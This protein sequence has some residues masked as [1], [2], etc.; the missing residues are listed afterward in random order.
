MNDTWKEFLD[1]ITDP[2]DVKITGL[3]V[4]KTLNP[5]FWEDKNHLNEEITNRLY[6]IAKNFF[7]SLGLDWSKIKDITVTGSLANFNWSKYS[8]ID[9]HILVDLSDFSEDEKM[10]KEYFRNASMM[11]N[12]TH[13]IRIKDH[14][15]EVYIQDYEE[16]HHSTG[17]YSVKE[18]KWNNRP[19]RY[20]AK[21]DYKNVQKKAAK[22]MDEIDEVY[23]MFAHKEYKQA[24][25]EAERLKDRIRKFRQGG[26]EEGGAYSVEN[27]AF[28]VLRRNDYLQK[29][30]SL[31]ILAYDKLMSMNGEFG[32]ETYKVIIKDVN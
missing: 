26:L 5:I 32:N 7:K 20:T 19:S 8:D 16:P 3:D 24:H 25:D 18:G 23:E 6:K 29:L 13:D 10:V 4:K 17:V 28:K 21:I 22:L 31:K 27:L 12:K 15:V 14:E 9:L 30:S 11:W 1:E 2:D